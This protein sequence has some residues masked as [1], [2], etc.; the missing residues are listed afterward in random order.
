VHGTSYILAIPGRTRFGDYE[1]EARIL[2]RRDVDV[3]KIGGD[4]SPFR[5][6]L[7]WGR[8]E[9]PVVVRPRQRGDRFR[10]LG[11]TG[12]KK[13]GKFLTTARVPRETRER[14]LVFADREKILWV[15]PVRIAEP[16]KIT[17]TTRQILELTVRNA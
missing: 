17:D 12:E 1:I 10:P 16:A 4:K 11:L 13:V 5:E 8:I 15:C 9:P 3:T 7:D 14:V 2:E 6:Y